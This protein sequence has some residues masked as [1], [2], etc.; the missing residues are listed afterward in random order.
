MR[1]LPPIEIVQNCASEHIFAFRRQSPCPSA[2]PFDAPSVGAPGRNLRARDACWPADWRPCTRK[3][4]EAPTARARPFGLPCAQPPPHTRP[5]TTKRG[6]VS[7]LSTWSSA[8]GRRPRVRPRRA[9]THHHADNGG[10][11]RWQLGHL[12]HAA[13]PLPR[14]APPPTVRATPRLVSART[15]ARQSALVPL[16][17]LNSRRWPHSGQRIFGVPCRVAPRGFG[18]AVR[19]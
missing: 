5:W 15:T 8:M 19:N 1:I 3:P 16:P 6:A 2:P 9:P 12:L 14:P 13:P 17:L 4:C 18:G 11:G 10:R 7:V